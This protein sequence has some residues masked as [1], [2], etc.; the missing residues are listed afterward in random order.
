VSPRDLHD[1]I[2]SDF[3]ER[4][5]GLPAALGTWFLPDVPKWDLT[6]LRAQLIY[7][8]FAVPRGSRSA[9]SAGSRRASC[10]GRRSSSRA[11]S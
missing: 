10:R 1:P 2:V 6:A 8:P 7:L 4:K 9:R 11:S 3:E 5:F